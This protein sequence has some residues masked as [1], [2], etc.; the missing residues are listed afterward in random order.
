MCGLAGYIGEKKLSHVQINN[1][2]NSMQSRGPD[3]FGSAHFKVKKKNVSLLHNRLKIIDLS[4]SA[5][6]PFSNLGYTLIFNGEIYNFK[7][8]KKNLISSYKFKT[9]S[10]TEVLLKNIFIKVMT[11]LMILGYVGNFI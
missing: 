7:E 1:C 10:D 4:N 9:N 5:N 8:I 6:Q 11:R 2:H 3:S